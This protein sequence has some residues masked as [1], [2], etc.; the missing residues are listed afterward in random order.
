MNV[1]YWQD[2]TFLLHI[3]VLYIKYRQEME[4]L[5]EEVFLVLERG[6]PLL[7]WWRIVSDISLIWPRKLYYKVD[8]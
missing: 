7:A 6:C 2:V 8:K 1:N 3:Y 5:D 4:G